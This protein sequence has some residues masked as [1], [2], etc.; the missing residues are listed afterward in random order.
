MNNPDGGHSDLELSFNEHPT[1]QD[2]TSNK[3]NILTAAGQCQS[4]AG[5][6]PF[7]S[8]AESPKNRQAL[9][10]Y[11]VAVTQLLH[12]CDCVI[13]TGTGSRRHFTKRT[14]V[15]IFWETSLVIEPIRQEK[16][17]TKFPTGVYPK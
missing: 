17:N 9:S 7:P 2:R 8:G 15:G 12:R 11:V 3:T 6:S 13:R 1:H 14:E 4:F 5:L 10:L 16:P